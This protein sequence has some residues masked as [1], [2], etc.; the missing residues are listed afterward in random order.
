MSRLLSKRTLFMAAFFAVSAGVTAMA[1]TFI[2]TPK[3]NP[4]AQS[5]ISSS[6]IT[7]GE[8]QGLTEH[9]A[10]GEAFVMQ[11]PKG[12]VLVLSYDFSLNKSESAVLGFGQ[13]GELLQESRFASLR[14]NSG[15]QTYILPDNLTPADYS[16]IYIWSEVTGAPISVAA[17]N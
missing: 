7:R 13:D 8:F 10:G 14:A 17:L 16:E 2:H 3:P 9:E 4:T 15:R 1:E 6:L 5:H 12:Y 11:T